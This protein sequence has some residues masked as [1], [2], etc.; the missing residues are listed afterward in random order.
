MILLRHLAFCTWAWL[1][2]ACVERNGAPTRDSHL[3][4]TD[5]A[6]GPIPADAQRSALMRFAQVVR[7]TVEEGIEAIPESITVLVIRG[8]TVRAAIDSGRVYRLSVTSH[9]FRT[10]DSLGPGTPLGRLLRV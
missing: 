3:L 2:L 9:R 4:L 8:D 1:A 5:E 6:V 7:D 10:V